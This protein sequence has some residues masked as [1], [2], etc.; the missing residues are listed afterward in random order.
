MVKQVVLKNAKF[1]ETTF[2]DGSKQLVGLVRGDSFVGLDLPS[3]PNPRQFTGELNPNYKA[4]VKTLKSEPEMFARKNASGITIFA[5]A[6]DSNGDGSYTLKFGN[7]GGLSNG[8]HTFN[9]LKHHGRADSYVKVTI[10]IGLPKENLVEIA[11]ALN[12]NKRLQAVSIQNKRGVF[13]WHK[14]AIGDDF[15]N[16]HTQYFEGDTGVIEVKEDIAFLN[17]FKR[18]ETTLEHM[19]LDNMYRSEEQTTSLLN[20]ISKGDQHFESSLRYIAKD[21]HEMMMYVTF[22][23]KFETQ[24]NT[25]KKS[26]GQNWFKTRK[27]GTKGLMKGLALL[28]VAGLAFEGSRLNKNNIVVWRAGYKT[29]EERKQFVDALFSKVFD[30][31]SVEEGSASTIVRQDSVRKK[32]LRHSAII[33]RAMLTERRNTSKKK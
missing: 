14:T 6:C 32:V 7:E 16:E 33:G 25:L 26:A 13:D 24:L 9:A 8:G 20:T 2:E 18:D 27:G 29:F 21:V 3:D 31:V 15:A 4:M 19:I 30:I 11:E 22:N 28:V 17:L 10:E 12:S 1:V 23:E 5:S